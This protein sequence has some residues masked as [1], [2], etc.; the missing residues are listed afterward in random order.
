MMKTPRKS[1][2]KNGISLGFI[3]KSIIFAKDKL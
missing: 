2:K 3:E 1:T